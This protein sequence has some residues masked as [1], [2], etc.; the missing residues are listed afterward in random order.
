MQLEKLMACVVKVAC[1]IQIFINFCLTLWPSSVTRVDFPF[2]QKN[3]SNE[4]KSVLI[5]H[6]LK[7]LSPVET[8]RIVSATCFEISSYFLA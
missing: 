3:L 8:F 5:I 7:I 6:G 2:M 4:L 1:D